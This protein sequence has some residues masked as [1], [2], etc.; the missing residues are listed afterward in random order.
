MKILKIIEKYLS[1]ELIITINGK[2]ESLCVFDWEEILADNEKWEKGMEGMTEDQMNAY[3]NHS[4]S[5]LVDIYTYFVEEEEYEEKIDSKEWIPFGVVGMYKPM[6]N[7]FAEMNNGGL[8]LFDMTTNQ[9]N[10]AVVF[11]LN[12]EEQRIAKTFAD[13]RIENAD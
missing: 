12:G 11:L 2:T 10:P 13:L 7:G 4:H 1:K 8:L 6:D 9:D 5:D 3:F